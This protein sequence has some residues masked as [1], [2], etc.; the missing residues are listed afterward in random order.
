MNES[1]PIK[2]SVLVMTYNHA[3]FI[4]KAIDSA[5]MQQ[6]DFNYEIIVSEDCST[7]GTREIVL[8]YQ[9][10]F[11][12]K[13]RLLLSDQNIHTNAVVTRG[14]YA[15]KGKYIALLDGDD[16]WTS[17]K[18]LQKQADFLDN[19]LECS[20]C[21]HNAQAFNEDSTQEP[22]N[23]TAPNQKEFSTLE[24][25]WGGNFIATCSTMFRNNLFEK[26]PD[27][28]DSFFPITDWPLYILIAQH[29]KIGYINEV[30]G[31]YRLHSGGLYS[32]YNEKQKLNK[33]LDFYKRINKFLNFK[34]NKII[35]TAISVYFYEWAEE[36]DKRKNFHSAIEC[37]NVYL[38]AKPI[39]S[40][41]SLKKAIKLGMKLYIAY[42]VTFLF[43]KK[44]HTI[45]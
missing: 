28:Y 32:P 29:G 33:T 10:R 14:I 6:T 23:W 20:M 22:W 19:Y 4:S 31:A 15:A 7:D 44:N 12:R 25:L 37:F 17:P 30:M 5:L 26:I 35:N 40:R 38:A 36:Y 1:D 16:Y 27:W 43:A 34:Y 21:F 11:P 42:G 39:N 18:K 3:K 24:D 2:V 8:D 13:I 9:Q 41:I 45:K